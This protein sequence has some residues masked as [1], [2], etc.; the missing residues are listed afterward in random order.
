MAHS[1]KKAGGP[2]RGKPRVRK[3][4]KAVKVKKAR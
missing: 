2:R 4:G 1:R 3:L